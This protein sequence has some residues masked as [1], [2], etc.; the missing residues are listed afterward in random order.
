[1]IPSPGGVPTPEAVALPPAEAP[2]VPP[3]GD[4]RDALLALADA[5]CDAACEVSNQSEPGTPYPLGDGRSV[6]MVAL[7]RWAVEHLSR[8]LNAYHEKRH[9]P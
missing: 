1:M 7:P 4:G 3:A 6:E 2:A 5:L 9:A 8:T